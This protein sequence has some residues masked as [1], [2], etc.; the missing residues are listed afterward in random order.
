[1]ERFDWNNTIAKNEDKE[2]D[3]DDNTNDT[4]EDDEDEDLDS[5]RYSIVPN[6]TRLSFL[7]QIN[8]LRSPK[9]QKEASKATQKSVPVTEK[10]SQ[11]APPKK[12]ILKKTTVNEKSN[13]GKDT[14][15]K[16]EKTKK[17][18]NVGFA[19]TLDIHEVENL[20]EDTKRQT[21]NFPRMPLMAPTTPSNEDENGFDSDLFAQLIGARNPDELHDKYQRRLDKRRRTPT[22]KNPGET[23]LAIQEGETR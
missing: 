10:S 4:D 12:S 19:E 1:M 6:S 23:R 16:K 14:E 5:Q 9:I 13:E 3:E 2:V 8:K 15:P 21:A 22:L 20:K 18:K 17:K 7:D 11:L